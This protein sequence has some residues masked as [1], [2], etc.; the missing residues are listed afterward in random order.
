MIKQ[1]FFKDIFSQWY[2]LTTSL[3]QIERDMILLLMY[4]NSSAQKSRRL[5]RSKF[6]G[7]PSHLILTRKEK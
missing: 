4:G 1:L 5:L 3:N 7:K 6:T 2:W